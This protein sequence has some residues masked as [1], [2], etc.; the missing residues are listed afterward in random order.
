EAVERW[1]VGRLEGGNVDSVDTVQHSHLPTFRAGALPHASARA[2]TA[3]PG[4]V[5]AIPRSRAAERND[6]PPRRESRTADAVGQAELAR[7][8]F[9]SALE[10][11]L[12]Q[13]QN[14]AG[15]A[16]QQEIYGRNP[17]GRNTSAA[18][19]KA[20]TRDDVVGFAG[21]RLRPTGSLLVVAGDI[22]LPRARELATQAFG[23]WHGAA[24]PAPAFPAPPAKRGTDIDRKSTRLNSSHGSISYA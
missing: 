1:T 6:A 2:C 20:I 23:S 15:R 18:A 13:A 19:Y 9:L 8:R 10:V 14:V 11:E 7:T 21:R 12:S 5:S 17:Y 3:A 16:F 24:P 22:T 4:P